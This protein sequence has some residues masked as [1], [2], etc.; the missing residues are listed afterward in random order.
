M[1]GER[2]G[3]ELALHLDQAYRLGNVAGMCIHKT[4]VRVGLD[5]LGHFRGK[6]Q[7]KYEIKALILREEF[8]IGVLD[9]QPALLGDGAQDMPGNPV[10]LAVRIS[11]SKDQCL[12]QMLPS[13]KRRPDTGDTGTGLYLVCQGSA[14]NCKESGP[15]MSYSP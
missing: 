6:L 4:N 3:L 8:F 14:I 13:D 10:I 15:E 2:R 9:R 11:I 12:F 1:V 7:R 5:L